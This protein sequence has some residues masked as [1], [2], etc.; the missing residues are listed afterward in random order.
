MTLFP[1]KL[2]AFHMLS[3]KCFLF[4]PGVLYCAG[5]LYFNPLRTKYTVLGHPY[6]PLPSFQQNREVSHS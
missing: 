2:K 6:L 4:P 1:S 5:S 3:S